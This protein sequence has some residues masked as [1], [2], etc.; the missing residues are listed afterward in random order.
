M[1]SQIGKLK[2]LFLGLL[3][4]GCA[5]LS[6]YSLIYA[7]P[8]RKCDAAGGWFSYRYHQ[9]AAPLYLPSITHRKPGE[10]A[11]INFH[12]D[13]KKASNMPVLDGTATS[14]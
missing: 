12:D 11:S 1:P 3:L 13:A 4:I 8:A 6:A 14:Q 5:A 7:I 10:P 2:Y 9:C